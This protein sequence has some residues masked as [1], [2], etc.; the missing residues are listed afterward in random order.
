MVEHKETSPLIEVKEPDDDDIQKP[1]DDK[2]KTVD[3]EE[4][5]YSNCCS[6]RCNFLQA[7]LIYLITNWPCKK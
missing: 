5:P 6:T 2:Q 3:D 4:K 1:D 7:I